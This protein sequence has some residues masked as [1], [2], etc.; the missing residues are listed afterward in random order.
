MVLSCK[1]TIQHGYNEICVRVDDSII[2]MIQTQGLVIKLS[3]YPVN[4]GIP[5]IKTVNTTVLYLY[6]ESPYTERLYSFRVHVCGTIS[7][8]WY[9]G[10][11]TQIAKFMGPTWG[12]TGPCRP[13]MGPMSAPWTLLL[14]QSYAKQT[15]WCSLAQRKTM[16]VSAWISNL[17][18]TSL[19]VADF[20]NRALCC[21]PNSINYNI[22]GWFRCRYFVTAW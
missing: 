7:R 12:P 10:K 21:I 17:T 15:R 5:I 14:G 18:I 1:W 11:Q 13:Q 4:V 6:R 2:P 8:L 9:C 3:S 16:E 22:H 19:S 20:N